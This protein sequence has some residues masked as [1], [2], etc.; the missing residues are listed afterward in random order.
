MPALSDKEQVRIPGGGGPPEEIPEW[1]GGGDDDEYRK[2]PLSPSL[3]QLGT[4]V[5]LVSVTSFFVALSVV[6][7]FSIRAQISWKPIA[8]PRGLWFSTAMIIV[9]SLW[10]ETARYSLRRGAV[11]IYKRYLRLTAYFGIAFL[12]SQVMAWQ[13]LYAQ[14]IYMESNPRGSMFYVFTGAHG[15]HLLGGLVW[16]TCLIYRARGLQPDA[17]PALRRQ[18]TMMGSAAIYW[19][20]MGVLWICLFTLLYWWGRG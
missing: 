11:A 4:I 15:I 2:H 18:R 12:V 6:F 7:F 1:G 16:L 10:L 17:E 14:G 8:I 3:G 5:V 9:S 13:N 20:F 19:H